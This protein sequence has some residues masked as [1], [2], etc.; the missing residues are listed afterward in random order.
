MVPFMLTT[1]AV[2][3]TS[4]CSDRRYQSVLV[5]GSIDKHND[6]DDGDGDDD[7]IDADHYGS[8]F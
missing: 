2:I 6:S 1:T 7:A 4:W 5:E 3:M 8:V